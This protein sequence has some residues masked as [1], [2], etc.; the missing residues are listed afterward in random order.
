MLIQVT[1]ES[2]TEYNRVDFYRCRANFEVE[3][4]TMRR[5]VRE[6]HIITGT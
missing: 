4:V 2:V 1:I 6:S 3:D 5:K